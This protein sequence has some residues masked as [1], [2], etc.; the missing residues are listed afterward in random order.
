MYSSMLSVYRLCSPERSMLER[1]V[2]AW[3]GAGG[4]GAGALLVPDCEEVRVSAA[5]ARR[6]YLNVLQHG[7]HGWKK[8]W[9]VCHTNKHDI[10]RT[11]YEHDTNKH[12]MTRTK[13]NTARTNTNKTRILLRTFAETRGVPLHE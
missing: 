12:N 2:A 1:A 13:T 3:G 8:R 6:G 4:G 10:T 11:Q 5:V 7:T 9:L